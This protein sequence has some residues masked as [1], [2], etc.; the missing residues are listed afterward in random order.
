MMHDTN[1]TGKILLYPLSKKIP[2]R[3]MCKCFSDKHPI[4]LCTC[5]K[6]SLLGPPRSWESSSFCR[7]HF[8]NETPGLPKTD[9]FSFHKL[10]AYNYYE[11]SV[12]V[13]ESVLCWD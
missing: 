8:S 11:V 12:S 4:N 5:S 7:M 6:K 3:C 10:F 9:H 2:I 1:S 13:A